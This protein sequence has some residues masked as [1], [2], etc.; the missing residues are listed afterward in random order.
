M[1]G[2][3]LQCSDCNR[4]IIVRPTA[5][6]WPPIAVES[7]MVCYFKKVNGSTMYIV[8]FAKA[9]GQVQLESSWTLPFLGLLDFT[10]LQTFVKTNT[11]NNT[12]NALSQICNF[13]MATFLYQ[14]NSHCNTYFIFF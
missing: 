2:P 9:Q 6:A 10:G 7:I 11:P 13:L 4:E 8:V 12:I 1:D 5:T 14:T 3:I